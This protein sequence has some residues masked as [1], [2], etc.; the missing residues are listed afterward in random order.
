MENAKGYRQTRVDTL[1]KI[2]QIDFFSQRRTYR[3]LQGIAGEINRLVSGYQREIDAFRP[4]SPDTGQKISFIF[5]STALQIELTEAAAKIGKSEVFLRLKELVRKKTFDKASSRPFGKRLEG[6][7]GFQER[8]PASDAAYHAEHFAAFEFMNGELQAANP[9]GNILGLYELGAAPA[10]FDVKGRHVVNFP[11]VSE[12]G[13]ECI[14]VYMHQETGYI[15][16]ERR[17]RAQI[18]KEK[19]RYVPSEFPAEGVV[20]PEEIAISVR[21]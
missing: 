9:Y 5:A 12:N 15:L 2:G 10:G 8:E 18:A 19:R 17:T 3:E 20:L 6:A 16:T 14:F 7:V 11:G 21:A 13:R 1:G 4:T